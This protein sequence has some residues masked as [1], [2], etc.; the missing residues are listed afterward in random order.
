MDGSAKAWVFFQEFILHG[1][2]HCKAN[3]SETPG[4]Q[5]NSKV[6][7]CLLQGSKMVTHWGVH[8][9]IPPGKDWWRSP[10]P[11]MSWF[12]MAP[13]KLIATELRSGDRHLVYSAHWHNVFIMKFNK[14]HGPGMVPVWSH[15]SKA[16]WH[17]WMGLE[18]WEFKKKNMGWAASKRKS[19]FKNNTPPSIFF[20]KTPNTIKNRKNIGSVFFCFHGVRLR[21]VK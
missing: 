12:I 11:C 5:L 19:L 17:P 21:F 4:S 20:R 9:G 3:I 6:R 16:K 13:Y 7:F 14:C 1:T 8:R 10:L 15:G 2:L 18:I